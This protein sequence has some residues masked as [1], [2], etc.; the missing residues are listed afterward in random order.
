MPNLIRAADN[1]TEQLRRHSISVTL[2]QIIGLAA[3]YFVVSKLGLLLAVPPGYATAVWPA[4][5]IALG[6]LLIYGVRLWPGV[7]IGSMFVNLSVSYGSS[8]VADPGVSEPRP[9]T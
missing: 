8:D 3:I 5:G 6:L 4:S 1:V 9:S 2:A 7:L